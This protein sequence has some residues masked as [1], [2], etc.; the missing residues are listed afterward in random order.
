MLPLVSNSRPTCISGADSELIAAREEG[1]RLLLAFL[2]DLEVGRGEVGDV[3]AAPIGH[4]DAEVDEVDFRAERR[5]LR[6]RGRSRGN[7]RE[8]NGSSWPHHG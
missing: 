1:D 2:D 4:G 6:G 5:L 8:R 7:E 3:V